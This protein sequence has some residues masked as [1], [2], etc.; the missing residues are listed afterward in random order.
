MTRTID[1]ESTSAAAL[2]AAMRQMEDYW[3]ELRGQHRLPQRR[4]VD[5]ARLS[6]ALPHAFLLQRVA[7]RV[8]RLRVAGQRL[9][10][11]LGMDP[12]GMPLST[13]FHGEAREVV[14]A[15]LADL[16][17]KPAIVELPLAARRGL[18][19]PR[20]TGRMIAL[21]L[22]GDDGLVSAALGALMVDGEIGTP[23]RRLEIGPGLTRVDP[24]VRQRPRPDEFAHGFAERRRPYLQLIVDND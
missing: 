3:H 1:R 4:A 5:P 19:R 20:L 9:T 15:R 2:Q 21:P 8:G 7:P 12:R 10:Q 18:A 17:D 22:I 16:F 6:A 23:P 14:G 11:L 13:F 24:L